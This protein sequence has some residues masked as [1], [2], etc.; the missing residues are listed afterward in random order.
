MPLVVAVNLDRRG[1]MIDT[2][3]AFSAWSSRSRIADLAQSGR[4]MQLPMK[5]GQGRFEAKSFSQSAPADSVS[6]R[7]PRRHA[8]RNRHIFGGGQFDSAIEWRSRS[9]LWA[10]IRFVDEIN[11]RKLRCAKVHAALPASKLVEAPP[12]F[13]QILSPQRPPRDSK[14]PLRTDAPQPTYLCSSTRNRIPRSAKRSAQKARKIPPH[15]LQ[16]RT[17]R[18]VKACDP[19]IAGLI[20]NSFSWVSV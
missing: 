9:I 3:P 1:V 19:H 10:A 16:H 4:D 15:D 6:F 18:H 20:H 7:R 11:C 5:A 12:I 13:P 17:K 14:A 8:R 2:A